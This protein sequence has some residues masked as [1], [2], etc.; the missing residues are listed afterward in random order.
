MPGLRMQSLHDVCLETSGK[1][2]STQDASSTSPGSIENA[3]LVDMS[4]GQAKVQ[5]G[6]EV[7]SPT[8]GI[9]DHVTMVRNE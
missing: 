7:K 3:T 1:L 6:G 9:V 4:L 8:G 2:A 5:G